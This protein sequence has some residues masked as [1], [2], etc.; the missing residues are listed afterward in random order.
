MW[1]SSSSSRSPHPAD[2]PAGAPLPRPGRP[3]RTVE[4]GSLEELERIVRALGSPPRA[5]HLRADLPD[6]AESIDGLLA[7]VSRGRAPVELAL[8]SRLEALAT[9]RREMRLGFS[10]VGDFA[11]ERL[12][13]KPGMARSLVRFAQALRTRPLLAGAVRKGEIQRR[14]AEVIVPVAFGLE[15]AGWVERARHETVRSLRAAVKEK[16][17]IEEPVDERWTIV[18]EAFPPEVGSA[19]GTAMK[20]AGIVLGPTSTEWQRL[21]AIV[22]EYVAGHPL[23]V[24]AVN[25]ALGGSGPNAA[26]EDGSAPPAAACW[27]D[28]PEGHLT[29]L[30]EWC[31][32][33]T[34]RW[35]FLVDVQPAPAVPR[36]SEESLHPDP[37]VL[38]DELRELAAI[39]HSWDE[40]L[41]MLG[42]L[43]LRFGVWRTAV[44]ASWMHYCE[45]RLGMGRS[46]IDQRIAL[47]R[48]M[49]RLPALR[50][51]LRTGVLSYEQARQVSRVA[52]EGSLAGWV[53][54]AKAMTSI[55][56][57][58]AVDEALESQMCDANGTPVRMHLHVPERVAEMLRDAFEAARRTAKRW[59]TPAE[60]LREIS[61]YFLRTWYADANRILKGTHGTVLRDD[62]LCQV[63][64]C[65]R[66]GDHVHHTIHRSQGGPLV[67]WN[68]VTACLPHHVA[69]HLGWVSVSGRAPDGLTWVLGEKEVAAAR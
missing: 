2:P 27:A 42:S 11:R 29:D 22:T 31:E 52:D 66:H 61:L 46:T 67:D 9:A 21:E 14:A 39:L 3:R 12:G 60:C 56:L 7:R 64:G 58:R 1:A 5:G 68:E 50:E 26:V 18:S 65:S 59:L 17:G 48:R 43:A 51:A 41:G 49:Q 57:Q 33:V 15:E 69:I 16:L 24:P 44:F 10:G 4:V 40:L 47:E 32:R 38:Q 45:E 62:G 34:S 36:P 25:D 23:D 53:E 54:R 6:I 55:A 13:M 20:V 19:L 63:P 28:V 30:K 37:Y 8:G 35:D